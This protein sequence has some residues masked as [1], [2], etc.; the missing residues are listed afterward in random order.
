MPGHFICAKMKSWNDQQK[1][2]FVA[3]RWIWKGSAG[4]VRG[5]CTVARGEINK[6]VKGKSEAPL[7]RNHT[8]SQIELWQQSATI[9]AHITTDGNWL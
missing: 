1:V 2:K 4:Q 3:N 5:L 6:I 7:Y 8:P 9:R